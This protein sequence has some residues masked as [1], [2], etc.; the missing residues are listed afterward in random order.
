MWVWKCYKNMPLVY[1][2]YKERAEIMII[3]FKTPFQTVTVQSWVTNQTFSQS[4]LL[5][6][7]WLIDG[8]TMSHYIGESNGLA[9][10]KYITS[11]YPNNLATDIHHNTSLNVDAYRPR[12]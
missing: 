4:S 9:R 5:G 11:H 12:A 10:A 7:H 6:I 1:M 2:S 8:V 3:I